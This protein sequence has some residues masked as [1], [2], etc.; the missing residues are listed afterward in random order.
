MPKIVGIKKSNDKI[1][2]LMR[3]GGTVTAN[4]QGIKRRNCKK[5]ALLPNPLEILA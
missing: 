1:D 5:K 3:K 2:F 4:I